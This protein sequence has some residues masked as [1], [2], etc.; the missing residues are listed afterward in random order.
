MD[1][2]TTSHMT[3]SRGNLMSYFNTSNNTTV[4]IGHNIPVIG[5]VHASL[6]TSPYAFNIQNVLH[7]PKLIKNMASVFLYK[8]FSYMKA[9]TEM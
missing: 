7:A 8:I 3:V 4:G 2:E 9:F 1:T 6:T 5:Y